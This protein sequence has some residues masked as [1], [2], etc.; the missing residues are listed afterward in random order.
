MKIHAQ[1]NMAT[2]I[3]AAVEMAQEKY[4]DLYLSDVNDNPAKCK[5]AGSINFEV[6]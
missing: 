6:A 5:Q 3:Q 2:V 4:P 1:V